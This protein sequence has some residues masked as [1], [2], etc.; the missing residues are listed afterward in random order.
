MVTNI[1]QSRAEFLRWGKTNLP[2][3]TQIFGIAAAI[4]GAS[5]KT[6][7]VIASLQSELQKKRELRESDVRKEKELRESDVRKEKELR[8]FD[9][10]KAYSDG[11]AFTLEQV[12]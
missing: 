10:A 2:F 9:I 12:L 3:L 6:G 11:R 7:S 8:G 4:I 1:S 5:L